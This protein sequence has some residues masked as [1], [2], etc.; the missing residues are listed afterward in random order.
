MTTPNEIG[1]LKAEEEIEMALAKYGKTEKRI[2]T[3]AIDKQL[4]TLFRAK[5]LMEDKTATAV[6]S[7]LVTDYLKKGTQKNVANPQFRRLKS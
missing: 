7:G 2:T 1:R 3:I 5:C 4:W 6:I